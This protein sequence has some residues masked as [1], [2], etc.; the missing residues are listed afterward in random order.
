M[1]LVTPAHLHDQIPLAD[2]A[3]IAAGDHVVEIIPGNPL[4]LVVGGSAEEVTSVAPRLLNRQASDQLPLPV[5]RLPAPPA[6]RYHQKPRP[7]PPQLV[8][9]RVET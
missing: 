3:H 8:L 2:S 6:H 1:E 5:F 7:A 9:D 4:G